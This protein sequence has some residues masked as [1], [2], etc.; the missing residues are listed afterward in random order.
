MLK[1][2]LKFCYLRDDIADSDTEKDEGLK[3]KR[4][5]FQLFNLWLHYLLHSYLLPYYYRV[6]VEDSDTD[7]EKEIKVKVGGSEKKKLKKK[8][9]SNINYLISFILFKILTCQFL[10]LFTYVGCCVV[11]RGIARTNQVIESIK[12]DTVPDEW[13]TRW[14]NS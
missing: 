14:I 3:K 4:F 9:V 13:S 8:Y 7:E 2:R 10:T 5:V 11:G 6:V 12:N 1:W